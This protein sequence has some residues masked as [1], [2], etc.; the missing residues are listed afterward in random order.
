MG[1]LVPKPPFMG[2][3]IPSAKPFTTHYW[4]QVRMSRPIQ[5]PIEFE[6]RRKDDKPAPWMYAVV[7]M[8]SVLLVYA[9][10]EGLARTIKKSTVIP[11][12]QVQLPD[13]EK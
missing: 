1:M 2:T 8:A 9:A 13:L 4:R 7:F 12:H 3:E 6:S 5:N 11:A 10:Q